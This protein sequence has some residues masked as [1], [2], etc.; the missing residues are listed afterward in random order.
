LGEVDCFA[1]SNKFMPIVL[2]VEAIVG[3]YYIGDTSKIVVVGPTLRG[4]L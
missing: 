3:R 2:G 4:K 1:A